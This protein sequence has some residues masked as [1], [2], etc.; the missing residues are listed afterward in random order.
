[1]R[2]RSCNQ[3][4]EQRNAARGDVDRRLERRRRPEDPQRDADRTQPGARALDGFVDESV[5]VIVRVRTRCSIGLERLGC[6]A[7]R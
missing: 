2:R 4:G 6:S 5:R 1:M 7:C 3:V